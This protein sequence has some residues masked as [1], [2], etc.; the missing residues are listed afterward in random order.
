MRY[1]LCVSRRG[2]ALSAFRE[3]P[4]GERGVLDG[5]EKK[6]V[7]FFNPGPDRHTLVRSIPRNALK[8]AR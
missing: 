3:L 7:P 2:L 8:F 5:W 6:N 4:K 1:A